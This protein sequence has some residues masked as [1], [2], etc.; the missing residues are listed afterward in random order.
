[1]DSR[2]SAGNI[3][4]RLLERMGYK[5]GQGL[6]KQGQGRVDPIRINDQVGFMGL[7]KLERDSFVLDNTA[8]KSKEMASLAMSKETEETRSKREVSILCI[9]LQFLFTSFRLN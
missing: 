8:L 1:M 6:G 2:L 7:G 9:N 5:Q 3:G 4:F